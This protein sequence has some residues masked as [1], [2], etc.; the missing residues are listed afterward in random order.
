MFQGAQISKQLYKHLLVSCKRK[1]NRWQQLILFVLKVLESAVHIANSK[2]AGHLRYH[3]MIPDRGKSFSSP[4]CSWCSD[5]T[6][7]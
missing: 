3:S 6:T 1:K 7:G 4:K 5:Y 2:Q